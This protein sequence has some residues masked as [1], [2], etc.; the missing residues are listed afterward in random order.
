[1]AN[2]AHEFWCALLATFVTLRSIGPHTRR[3][4]QPER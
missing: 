2:D 4:I 3:G 1:M